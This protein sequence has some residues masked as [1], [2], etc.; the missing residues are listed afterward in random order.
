MQRS[1]PPKRIFSKKN[2]P[3]LPLSLIAIALLIV[4]F[5][6]VPTTTPNIFVPASLTPPL[7]STPTA[8][9]LPAPTSRPPPIP[10]GLHGGRIIFTCTRGEFNQI[11][12]V[13][14]D[15]SGLLQLTDAAANHYYP[16]MSPKGNALVFASNQIRGTFDLYLLI[17]SSSTRQQLTDEIGNVFSPDFSPD[18]E[19]LLFI[20][21]TDEGQTGLWVMDWTGQNPRL[22]FGGPNYAGPN[23]L[24]GAAWAPNGRRIALSMTVNQ[25]FEYEIFLLD[26]EKD[27]PPQRL[28]FGLLGIGGSLDWSPDGRYVLIAAGPPGDK[29]IFRIDADTGAVVRLTTGGNNNSAA[30]S[31]DGEWI[32]FNSLRNNDQADLYLMRADGSEERQLTFD[33]EPDW[34]PQWEP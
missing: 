9:S 34:Q 26:L 7:S 8:Q 32:V 12:M 31:P 18:G 15:G 22:L 21:R 1:A 23:T 24:V 3:R 10:T 29:D 19:K 11:C 20:N 2:K 5:L 13:N 28:T 33:P 6:L 25:P 4:L 16:A 14:R 17:F 30:Y 27:D